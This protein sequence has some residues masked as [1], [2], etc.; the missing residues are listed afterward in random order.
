[1]TYWLSFLVMAASC[2]V[3]ANSPTTAPPGSPPITNIMPVNILSDREF[4]LTIIVV[5]F[6]IAVLILEY[7][8][9][10]SVIGKNDEL[11]SRTILAS[12]IIVGTLVLI[13][14][15]LSSADIAPALGLFG[16]IAGYLLG[17]S[18]L[19]RATENE[20]PN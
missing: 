20:K 5:I 1:M 19:R 6:G 16:T 18:D 14:A 15:G 4:W 2:M 11:I 13:A 8:L 12:L 7:S 10:K 17:R 9:L 3:Y